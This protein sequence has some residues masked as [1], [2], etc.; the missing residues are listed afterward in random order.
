[1]G[2][3]Q[4][5][6]KRSVWEE[7]L[8]EGRKT[9]IM[10][11]GMASCALEATTSSGYSH[12]ACDNCDADDEEGKKRLAWVSIKQLAK[13]PQMVKLLGVTLEEGESVD[14]VET[15]K[16]SDGYEG[17]EVVP[18]Q[19]LE[20]I[21]SLNPGEVPPIY[22]WQEFIKE[23]EEDYNLIAFNYDWRRWGDLTYCDE[24]VEQFKDVVE[25][26]AEKSG[27]HVALVGHSLGTQV[28]NYCLGMMTAKWTQEH[29]CDAVLVGPATMGSPS[30]FAAYA[31]GPSTVTHSSSI[32][33]ASL[34][35]Y[36]I[37]DV[38]SSWPCMLTV[39][40]LHRVGDSSVFPEDH[41]FAITPKTTYYAKDVKQFLTDL[42][43]DM[44]H[45]EEDDEQK[46]REEKKGVQE[47]VREWLEEHN[48]ITTKRMWKP[49][50]RLAA[51]G[52]SG[53]EKKLAPALKAP[54]CRVHL[55]YSD[56]IPTL[57]TMSFGEKLHK[58]AK[59]T[60]KVPGDDTIT[61]D[62]VERMGEAWSR[63]GCDVKLHKV[64]GKVH[65]KG[66]ISCGFSIKRFKEIFKDGDAEYDSDD[67]ED[68]EEEEEAGIL[69]C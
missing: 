29:V 11:H 5:C 8:V 1:M 48:L 69:G 30:I 63:S 51:R 6:L 18:V 46:E 32:P 36:K 41:P 59:F 54:A 61:A 13:R 49:G 31:N 45:A 42:A 15:I 4:A 25:E 20:G 28:I 21:R 34:F 24:L 12:F 68:E 35:E 65:H 39:F 40:P 37:A 26:V 56:A 44:L 9:I 67:D 57:A 10:V 17:V 60:E 27:Q 66:L 62:S 55:I 14:G 43:A 19:G 3:H 52:F 23:F 2:Q 22:L 7:D 38:A 47:H 53:I 58:K 50:Y 64:P 16:S 33:V